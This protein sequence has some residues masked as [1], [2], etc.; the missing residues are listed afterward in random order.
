MIIAIAIAETILLRNR[1][2]AEGLKLPA[3]VTDVG[4]SRSGCGW[5]IPYIHVHVYTQS[6]VYASDIINN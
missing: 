1:D 5:Y 4:S 3:S 6:C 2:N